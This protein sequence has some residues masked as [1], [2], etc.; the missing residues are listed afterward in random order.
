MSDEQHEAYLAASV[1]FDDGMILC[2]EC[3]KSNNK[4]STKARHYEDLIKHN[5]SKHARNKFICG[6][7][8]CSFYSEGEE[9]THD[10]IVHST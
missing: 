10:R 7:C 3:F 8:G 6:K 5:K 2:W 9:G 4:D 1:K